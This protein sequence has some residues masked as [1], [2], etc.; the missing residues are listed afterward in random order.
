MTLCICY[1]IVSYN[2][3]MHFETGFIG[4]NQKIGQPVDRLTS[5]I[6]V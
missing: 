2:I 1:L 5:S 6:L 4:K 3:Y